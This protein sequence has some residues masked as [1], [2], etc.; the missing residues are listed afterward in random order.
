MNR[1]IISRDVCKSLGLEE[2]FIQVRN[3]G[4]QELA[5]RS[6]YLSPTYN[7]ELVQDD[8]RMALIPTKK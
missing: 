6:F 8:N 7:W 3:S 1:F 4:N 2:D 5:K